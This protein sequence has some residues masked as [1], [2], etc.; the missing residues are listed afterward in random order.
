MA[1]TLDIA[2]VTVTSPDRELWPGIRKRDLIAYYQR[3]APHMLPHARGRPLTLRR[4]PRGLSAPGFV[5]QHDKG[6]FHEAVRVVTIREEGGETEPHFYIED[7]AGLVALTQVAALELH[8]WGS[9]ADDLE[10]PDRLVFDLDPDPSVGFDAVVHAAKHIR[11]RL[12]AG[13]IESWPMLSGGK[14]VHVVV[15]LARGLTWRVLT[16]YAKRFAE[17]LEVEEPDR[18]LAGMSKSERKGRIFVD[19]LRNERGATAVLPFS[20]RARLDAPVAMPIRWE[21]LDAC[22]SAA[23]FTL[24]R[25]LDRGVGPPEDWARTPQKLP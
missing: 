4:Y 23:A 12:A 22:R 13:G 6:G 19:W 2:G 15:A 11:D 25:V 24:R 5:Q 7:E 1:D 10:H 3:V 9:R 16:A 20:T 17:A 21:D 18:F 8:G 14:G